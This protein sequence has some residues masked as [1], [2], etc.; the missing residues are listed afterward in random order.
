M[1]LLKK[2]NIEC[3]VTILTVNHDLNSAAHW[4]DR[5]I[6]LKNGEVFCSGTPDEILQPE[7]LAALFDTPFLR[8]ETLMPATGEI[9]Q[10]N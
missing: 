6:G 2:I 10:N 1:K 8:K 9:N 3:G 4:S 5:L 7:Q